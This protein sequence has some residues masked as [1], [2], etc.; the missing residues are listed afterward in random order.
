MPVCV[1]KMWRAK[2]PCLTENTNGFYWTNW[3]I[4]PN[5]QSKVKVFNKW[6]DKTQKKFIP[7]GKKAFL[8]RRRSS[9]RLRFLQQ[10]FLIVSLVDGDALVEAESIVQWIYRGGAAGIISPAAIW[11]TTA[12]RTVRRSGRG[13]G[14]ARL[15]DSLNAVTRVVVLG[16]P[17]AMRI[18]SHN[19]DDEAWTAVEPLGPWIT[20]KRTEKKKIK[21]EI[22]DAESKGLINQSINQSLTHPINRPINHPINQSLTQSSNPRMGKP[23]DQSINQS[24]DC[25]QTLFTFHFPQFSYP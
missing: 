1:I 24:K 13:T 15:T 2:R 3:V 16:M 10:V 21:L 4:L 7:S 18:R 9:A 17:T 23:I 22:F 14:V 11:R 5:F 12:I 8:S 19:G 25:K 6:H 20:R